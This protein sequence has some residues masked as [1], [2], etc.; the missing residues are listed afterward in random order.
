MDLIA[1]AVKAARR[2]PDPAAVEDLIAAQRSN[3]LRRAARLAEAL[4]P[5]A[6]DH[7]LRACLDEVLA[8]NRHAD[9]LISAWH[10]PGGCR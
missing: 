10:T 7:V 6:R 4:A 8:D 3:R 1:A 5:A 2:G 9:K